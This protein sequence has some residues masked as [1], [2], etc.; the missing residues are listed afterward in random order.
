MQI[1]ETINQLLKDND[2]ADRTSLFQFQCFILGKEPTTQ[3][4]LHQCLMELKSR[5]DSLAAID[6]EIAEQEDRL[7]LIDISLHRK[8]TSL[9]E[10]EFTEKEKGILIRQTDRAK[11]A[12]LDHLDK[13]CRTRKNLE[14]EC[15]FFISAFDQLSKRESL[16]QW[17]DPEVQKE[18]WNEK[19]RAEVNIRLLLRQLPDMET[20]RSIMS[21]HDDS[22]LKR[23]TIEMLQNY[24]KQVAAT[25]QQP[26]QA[27]VTTE[28]D[29]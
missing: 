3:G 15:L 17:D 7:A 8:L 28:N 23:K 10:D 20:M 1:R 9:I 25:Q 14:E 13:I 2:V 11:T 6:L 26:E 5:R 29:T 12:T 19:L 18:Y 24:N 22:P 27:K 21:L 16:K 4:K